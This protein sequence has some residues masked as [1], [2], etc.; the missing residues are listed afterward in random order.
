MDAKQLEVLAA[1]IN[2]TSSPNIRKWALAM[3][4]AYSDL[5]IRIEAL[6]IE[7]KDKGATYG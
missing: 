2:Q 4:Q 7:A 3:T 1:A 5:E 6:E